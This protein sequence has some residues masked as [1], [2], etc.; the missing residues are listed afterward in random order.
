M[1]IRRVLR[2]DFATI[3]LSAA[4][5]IAGG[6]AVV[7]PP[8]GVI[9]ALLA[10]GAA[11]TAWRDLSSRD[12]RRVA[13]RKTAE[14]INDVRNLNLEDAVFLFSVPGSAEPAVLRNSLADTLRGAGVKVLAREA[15]MAMHHEGIAL[16]YRPELEN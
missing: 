14:L 10:I 16:Y 3:L 9:A 8:V 1:N 5:A 15:M 11:A 6:V 13:R 4:S 2:P 12:P 7:K